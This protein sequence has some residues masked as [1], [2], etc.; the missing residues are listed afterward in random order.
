[1]RRDALK[2][3]GH[4]QLSL[5]TRRRLAGT[6]LADRRGAAAKVAQGAAARGWVDERQPISK[7]S[8][9]LIMLFVRVLVSMKWLKMALGAQVWHLE[10]GA[11]RHA[12]V[13]I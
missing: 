2:K 10:R 8:T 5:S 7:S 3:S 9:T 6:I 11:H 1:V 4:G 12:H 13:C